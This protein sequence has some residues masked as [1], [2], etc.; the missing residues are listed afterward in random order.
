MK[1][2]L[3]ALAAS[4]C[5]ALAA[6]ASSGDAPSASTDASPSTLPAITAPTL[7]TPTETAEPSPSFVVD[8]PSP[9]PDAPQG[10]PCTDPSVSASG[11][12]PIDFGR[13]ADICVGM[14]FA[15]ATAAMPGPPIQGTGGC[16]WYADVLAADDPGLYV[17]AVTLPDAPGD[18]IFMFRMAWQGS[19]ANAAAYDAPATAAGISVGSTTAEVKA[20]YP[21]AKAVTIDDPSIGQRN[22]LVVAGPSSM[23]LVF[24]VTEGRVSSV[25]WGERIQ[26]GSVAE[27]CA[28]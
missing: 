22:Q 26:N 17:S 25:Y 1:T 3:V 12:A 2:S 24:D 20:A 28:L 14:S 27:L 6:C 5:L 10:D 19:L 23:S 15:E 8:S 16:P 7:A 21:G 18:R 9:T 4:C 11:L 13:Y